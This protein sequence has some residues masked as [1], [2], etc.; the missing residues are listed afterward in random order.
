M[1]EFARLG[2]ELTENTLTTGWQIAPSIA[3]FAAGGFIMAWQSNDVAQD[4]SGI[5][6]KYQRYNSA[7]AKTGGEILV[8]TS[9]TG[10][11][12]A[13]NVTTLASGGFVI[14]WQTSD[15]AQDGSGSAIKAQLY[16]AAGATVGGEFL[17]NSQA[18]LGQS[19]P[20]ITSLSDGGF[21]ITWD[22]A[23]TAQDG[24]G[25]AIKGQRYSASGTAAGS[26]FLVNP[27]G[28][29]SEAKSS[30]AGLAGGGFVVT[31]TLGTGT[32]A[33][34]YAQ[35]FDAAGVKLGS[36]VLVNGANATNDDSSK[37]NGLVNG[38]FVVTWSAGD[39]TIKA[40]LFA[41][42]GSKIGAEQVVAA[43]VSD[44][45]TGATLNNSKPHIE[46]LADGGFIVTWTQAGT[47]AF[48]D[49]VRGRHYDAGGA[50]QGSDFS[51]TTGTDRFE[52]EGDVAVDGTGAIFTAW[53]SNVSGVTPLNYDIRGTVLVD[54]A[55][56]A[57]T[58]LGGGQTASISVNENL[59]AVTTLTATNPNG[60]AALTYSIA[61]GID[62]ARFAINAATGAL[63]FVSA[64]NYESP[65]DLGSNNV[66]DVL[67]AVSDGTYADIQAIAVTVVNVNEGQTFNAPVTSYVWSS[68]AAG[69]TIT[70]PENSSGLIATL[71][72]ID[73]DN[74]PLSYSLGGADAALFAINSATGAVSIVAP[75][76]YEAPLD[77]GA[78]NDFSITVIASDG[79]ISTSRQVTINVNNVNEAPVVTSGGGGAAAA[80]TVNENT[81]LITTLTATDPENNPRTWS[82]FGGADAARFSIASAYGELYFPN[83]SNF[84]APVDAN[85]DNVY[86][87][88]VQVSDG[89]GNTDV[90]TLAITVANVNEAP[91]ITSNGGGASV[92]VSLAE[93]AASVTTVTSTDPDGQA[94]VY[95]I[96]GGTDAASFAIDAATGALSFVAA[97]DFE[98]PG[99][100][101]GDNVYQVVV[102]AS[103]GALS[104]TQAIS[105]TVT[106]ANEAPAITSNGGGATA[107]ASV[108][109][110]ATAVLSVAAT[111]PG[112]GAL[113]Y[114][115]SGGADAAKFAIDA[116]T[117]ALSFIAAPNFEAP[118]DAG[119][120]NV[121]DVIVQAS[122]GAAIDT[123]A[124][125]VTVTNVNEAPAIAS[126]S[127]FSISENQLAVTTVAASDPD[128][129]APSFSITGGADAALFAIDAATGA[130]SFISAPD[131]EAPGDAGANNAYDVIVQVSD[132]TLT[133]SKALTIAVTDVGETPVI[134]SNGGG[135]TASA[136]V[137]ENAT[138]VLTVAATN[139]GS[140][141][142]AYSISGG[143]DAAKFAIDVATGALSFIAAPNF[144][145]PADA[146]A[147]NVYDVI[148]QASAGA[149]NDTQAI[150]VTVTNVNEAPA[151]T[152]GS[153]FAVVENQ[154]A[155]ATLAASDPDGTAP[156]FSIA[157]GAD[158]ALFTIDAATG[159]LSFISAP[160]FEAPGDAGSNNVYDVT[161]QASDG[162]LTGTK[163]LTITVTDANEAPVITSNGGGATASALVAEN[164]TAV[165]TVAA[166]NPGGGALAYSISGGADAAKF[167]IDAATGALS[168][169]AAPNFEVPGDAGAD[170]V[171]DV[172]VQASAGALNDTQALAVSVTNANEAPAITS[173]SSFSTLENQLAV[174]TVAASDPD[175][176]A[177]TF[178]ISG[179]AD[180]SLFTIDAATGALSFISAP[181]FEA[182]GDAG[183]NNVYDVTV[184]ASDGSLTGTK[185][186]NI[187]VGNANEAVV[188]VS[189]GGGASA[190][191]TVGEGVAAV[192]TVAAS[193]PE[194]APRSYAISGGADAA[195]FAIDAAT[196]ALSFIAA[197]DFEAPGDAG[198]DNV[199][200]VIVQA[201]DGVT[202]DTQALAVTVGNGNEAPVITSN[203]GG[204][205]AA[206]SVS[207]NGTAVLTVA[208][209]DPEGTLRTYSIAGGVDAARFAIDAAT[210][211]LSFIAAPN[212]EAPSDAGGNNVYD[213]IVQASDGSLSDS[214]A[215][216]VTVT[217]INEAPV[218]TS[219]GG[220]GSAGIAVN[221]NTTAV[222]TVI[223]TDPEGAAR[224]YSITGGADAA[225]FAINA[226]TGV[227]TFVAAPNYEA[228]GD[229]G[230]NNV[231]DVIVRASDGVNFATQT[232]AV[233]IGN[234]VDGST[235]NG[236]SGGNTLT[237]TVA[238]DTINGL[239]GNDTITGGG[240]AD[241]LTGGTGADTFRYNLASDS[242]VNARDIITDFTRSQSDKISLNPM[243]AN[244][245]L[246][247]NQNFAFIGTSAFSNVAGQVRFEQTGGNTFVS[248]DVNGDG[249]ADFQIQLT[250]TIN[251][252]ASDFVL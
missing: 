28:L 12:T 2:L 216:A 129:T 62:A 35:R 206:V 137:S 44:P 16:D 195:K 127:S 152:S 229:A 105:V 49:S 123:Q 203:G 120:D 175:G 72:A 144:E 154:L 240:G 99:D 65:G 204:A 244:A 111:N 54:H 110:N 132:G 47:M 20:S 171:Y 66:Y 191:I 251:L 140:G 9:A 223:A 233:T 8:N 5:A 242:A 176:T 245:N 33:D 166:T 217:G 210:G 51:I 59:V 57:F 80:Y 89:W 214:Q 38:N 194:N 180:A 115:I 60:A 235:I 40:Q 53:A 186:L 228:P 58:S 168:F 10:D 69:V 43:P 148:V 13:P 146:G 145:T 74:N 17:V 149:A 193:D 124:I 121:Y 225:K 64:R 199:Y 211:A 167:A 183:S 84:E 218:I 243:D 136:S 68:N 247:G 134:T 39:T 79:T 34:V 24:S 81:S 117:G 70:L 94:R 97:P 252:L 192:T 3:G 164:A 63:S 106:D 122:A 19:R 188:I 71:T 101:N 76:N 161:V 61:G 112:G 27:A 98:A 96:T 153:S 78:N 1:T 165:L 15:T 48:Q 95:S 213:V 88:T 86:E 159:A 92:S 128:G 190:S 130:L 82:I 4:G 222:A 189:N 157:G 170:N 42:N 196:G 87:V 231:Y 23:D 6:I 138:A 215:I 236:T 133:D 46:G 162:S 224:T 212:F 185:A 209:S 14:S 25:A 85:G 100:A 232:L 11:Q 91:V 31:W 83:G 234:V 52:S 227:L 125:A 187:S 200:D 201:S 248:G 116:A 198:A 50:A 103:D 155:V 226:T 75:P 30:A 32:G 197:T 172:V 150:A 77:D 163:A 73:G 158:A 239:G 119:G 221:E 178:T 208:S 143:A 22:T 41:A 230:A 169:I 151:I 141:A 109:E 173:G 93:N 220:G 182:P 7:G 179:G 181:D 55:A 56:P 37:V 118:G 131:F 113:A 184:Q 29:G 90:Q 21:V 156:T 114:S 107:S 250:G 202:T 249:A 18:A 26:E 104:D 160:D 174:T 205:N 246:S 139:P 177:P 45:T 67:V 147:N 36:Q 108:A 241:M 238:E 207:E 142:L 237:G 102:G 135:A 219:N 126:G